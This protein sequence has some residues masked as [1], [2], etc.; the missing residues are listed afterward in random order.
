MLQWSNL[1]KCGLFFNVHVV[2]PA[3]HT[4]LTFI[5]QRLIGFPWY[6]N[7]HPDPQKNISNAD[8]YD[9]IMD[10]ILL[11]SQVYFFMMGNSQMV[12]NQENMENDQP[13][14]SH[15]HVQ[16]PL[17]PQTCVQGI[18]LVKQN[19]LR[20]FSAGFDCLWQLPQQVG[21]EFPIDSLAFLKVVN[22]HNAL[23]IPEDGGHHLPCR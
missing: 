3:V 16:Q 20:K 9:L 23:C 8:N 4:L 14:Q 11:P 13:V 2:S 7:S 18:V 1:T 10:P 6:R 22:E 21:I 12:P 17:Q 5:L 19:Y 15:T